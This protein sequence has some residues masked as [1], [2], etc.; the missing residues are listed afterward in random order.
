MRISFTADGVTKV[1]DPGLGVGNSARIGNAMV[2]D[3]PSANTMIYNDENGLFYLKAN[4]DK[5]VTVRVWM[6]GTDEMCDDSL[7]E[8][9]FA[10]RLRF[11]GTDQNNNRLDGRNG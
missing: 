10:I 6:E 11:E 2:F 7:K 9:N 1:Y 3:L 8:G 5:P 4:E